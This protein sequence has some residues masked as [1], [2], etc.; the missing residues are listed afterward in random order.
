MLRIKQSE[1][2][3]DLTFRKD[4][5]IGVVVVVG[6]DPL[7]FGVLIDKKSFGLVSAMD[8]T[9]VP[10]GGDAFVM[11]GVEVGEEVLEGAFGEGL[12]EIKV[13]DDDVGVCDDSG[14]AAL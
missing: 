7:E 9:I 1:A 3:F 8:L 2:N 5:S 11:V 14:H 13:V 12:A 6:D 10:E 4:E